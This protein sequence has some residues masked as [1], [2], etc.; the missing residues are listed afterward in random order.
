M[1][2]DAGEKIPF[3]DNIGKGVLTDR[4]EPVKLWHKL[5]DPDYTYLDVI[6]DQVV[7]VKV[8]APTHPKLRSKLTE[9]EKEAWRE[10]YS[11]SLDVRSALPPLSN[12]RSG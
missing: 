10:E 9:K 1:V 12:S 7:E 8:Y 2:Q 4:K 6:D 3:K 5:K 11:K